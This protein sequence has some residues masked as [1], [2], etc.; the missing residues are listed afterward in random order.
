MQKESVG[1]V[2]V[3]ENLNQSYLQGKFNNKNKY[4]SKIYN[5]LNF[6]ASNPEAGPS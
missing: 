4:I 3:E 2:K 6:G 1:Q 5:L